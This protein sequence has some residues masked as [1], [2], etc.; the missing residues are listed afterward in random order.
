M[1]SGVDTARHA[2][3]PGTARRGPS[4][5]L[6]RK[7]ASFPH[8][9]SAAPRRPSDPS[10]RFGRP[11]S[12]RVRGSSRSAGPA[13]APPTPTRPPELVSDPLPA[14]SA[15]PRPHRVRFGTALTRGPGTG[16]ATI[17]RRLR[18]AAVPPF[19]GTIVLV[20]TPSM[21]V[22]LGIL[23]KLRRISLPS[24]PVWAMLPYS[25]ST[26]SGEG[27]P[28]DPGTGSSTA[29]ETESANPCPTSTS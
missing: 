29:P 18:P 16:P 2:G 5:P 21:A 7:S 17:P 15:L 3:L 4:T 6:G 1:T 11:D 28:A 27:Q 12:P 8:F 9:P 24:C 10:A 25:Q 13:G 19:H 14:G 20:S 26:P 23:E 22:K